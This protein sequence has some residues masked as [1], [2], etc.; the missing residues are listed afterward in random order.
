MRDMISNKQVVHLGN[1]SVSGTTPA[2]SDYVDLRGYDAASIVVVNNTVTD[3]GTASGF[4][5]TLQ[6]SA[7]T[8]GASAGT[9]AAADTVDGTTTVTVT[10]DSADNAVAGG[11]GY[12]G[13]ERY[14]GITVTGTTGSN[15]D[16]S[17]LAV[18]NKP[19]RAPTT[20]VGTA[21]ART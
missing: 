3:A 17:V 5:V 13:K 14:V 12:R 1:V 16:I 21:V 8:A 15:A 11:M 20:F 4:T 7:D 2:T 9:V 6:E 10:S 18:L 19:H